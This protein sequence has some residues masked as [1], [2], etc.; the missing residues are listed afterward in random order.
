MGEQHNLS[1]GKTVGDT[2]PAVASASI[3]VVRDGSTGLEVFMLERH[4]ET[5]FAGGALVFPGGKVEDTDRS[6]PPEQ[7]DGLRPADVRDAVGAASDAAALGLWVAAVREAFEEAGVLWARH[8]G[9]SLAASDLRRDD[10]LTARRRLNDRGDAWNWNGWLR[11]RE[12]VLDLGALSFFAWW[13][14][15]TG[16][17]RRYDTRFFVATVPPQQENVPTHDHIETVSSRWVTPQAALAAGRAG[18]VTLVYPTRKNLETLAGYTTA[19]GVVEAARAGRT[20]TRRLQPRLVE[21]EGRMLVQ[22]PDGGSPE[23]G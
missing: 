8:A 16:V 6:L 17:H 4:I 23:E 13:V 10:F 19:A 2:R 18:E 7:W 11:D 15:P 3:V 9:S 12:L 20:D 21:V 5:D 22:H 14:T 1:V